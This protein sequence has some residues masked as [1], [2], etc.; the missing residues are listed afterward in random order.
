MLGFLDF[1]LGF[2][3]GCTDDPG[4]EVLSKEGLDRSPIELEGLDLVLAHVLA[5]DLGD[6]LARGRKR[7]TCQPLD[8]HM[9]SDGLGIAARGHLHDSSAPAFL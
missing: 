8:K 3:L 5:L 4:S 2:R 7:P 6:V 1:S 9:Q